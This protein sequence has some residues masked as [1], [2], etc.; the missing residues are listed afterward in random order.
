MLEKQWKKKIGD[1]KRNNLRFF[2]RVILQDYR[3]N[4]DYTNG[5]FVT[6]FYFF[7]L[8]LVVN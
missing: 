4:A 5:H 1:F 2:H 8:Y 3:A 7:V 6:D